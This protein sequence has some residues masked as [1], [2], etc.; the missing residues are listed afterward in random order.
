LKLL[1]DLQLYGQNRAA[2]LILKEMTYAII[3]TEDVQM[4]KQ[5]IAFLL[6]V[7]LTACGGGSSSTP[8]STSTSSTLASTESFALLLFKNTKITLTET[9]ITAF[10]G[11]KQTSSDITILNF[12]GTRIIV[13]AFDGRTLPSIYG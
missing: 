5:M 8:T 2:I 4:L 3:I 12:D 6:I 11:I 13:K 7:L 1:N 9:A 10:M